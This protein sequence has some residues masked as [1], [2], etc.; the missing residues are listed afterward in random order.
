MNRLVNYALQ[1]DYFHHM[2]LDTDVIFK[3]SLSSGDFS[4]SLVTPL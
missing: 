3:T 1:G 4:D 2:R